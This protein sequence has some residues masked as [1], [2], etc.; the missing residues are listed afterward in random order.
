MLTKNPRRDRSGCVVPS[1]ATARQAP[2]WRA[3]ICIATALA[4]LTACNDAAP[5][6]EPSPYAV[7]RQALTATP[8][9]SFEEPTDWT[10]PTA[11]LLGSSEHTDGSASLD[12]ETTGYTVVTNRTPAGIG[13]LNGNG[14]SVDVRLP[15]LPVSGYQAMQLSLSA[16]SVNLSGVFLGQRELGGMPPGEWSTVQ[17]TVPDYAF[18]AL[19]GGAQDVTIT[20]AFI[21]PSGAGDYLLDRLRFSE[22]DA[23]DPD[24]HEDP[25][26]PARQVAN[27][28]LPSGETMASVGLLA[29]H[30]LRVA[31]RA[32]LVRRDDTGAVAANVGS[33]LTQLGVSA[34]TGTLISAAPVFLAERSRVTSELIHVGNVV[35]Q[36]DTFVPTETVV[37]T[38]EKEAFSLSIRSATTPYSAL[39]VQPD[40]AYGTVQPGRYPSLRLNSRSS[41]R[42]VA[43]AYEFDDFILEPGAVLLLDDADGPIFVR[44]RNTLT[45]RADLFGSGP[46]L[47]AQVLW[48]YEGSATAAIEAPLRGTVVAPNGAVKLATLHGQAPAIVREHRGAV[49]ARDIQLDADVTFRHVPFAFE[50]RHTTTLSSKRVCVNEPIRVSVDALPAAPGADV[51]VAIAGTPTTQRTL[52]FKGAP[53]LRQIPIAISSSGQVETEIVEVEIVDCDE[54]YLSIGVALAL[55]VPGAVEFVVADADGA[56]PSL[57]AGGTYRWTFG[58]GGTQ[59]TPYPALSHGYPVATSTDGLVRSFQVAVELIDASGEVLASGA[60]SV[61]LIN[62]AAMDR[63]AGVLRPRA[64]VVNAPERLPSGDYSARLHIDNVEAEEMSLNEL[65]LEPLPCSE[66]DTPPPSQVTAVAVTVPANTTEIVDVEIDAALVGS[67]VCAVAVSYVGSVGSVTAQASAY[68]ELHATD[69]EVLSDPATAE[70][71]TFALD[72]GLVSEPDTVTD[73]ELLRLARQGRLPIAEAELDF[74]SAPAP[75]AATDDVIGLACVPGDAPPRPGVTCQAVRDAAGN[76]S[77]VRSRAQV[78]NARKGDTLLSAG[79]SPITGLLKRVDP[80]Q[81]FE[82]VGIMSKDRTE[83]RSAFAQIEQIMRYPSSRK[84]ELCHQVRIVWNSKSTTRDVQGLCSALASGSTL[85]D[86]TAS[87]QNLCAQLSTRARVLQAEIDALLASMPSLDADGRQRVQQVVAQLSASQNTCESLKDSSGNPALQYNYCNTIDSC[88]S[89]SQPTDG[90]DERAVK[91][92]WPGSVTQPVNEAF[93]RG[94]LTA[95]DG[96]RMFATVFNAHPQYCGDAS[97]ALVR[98]RVAK[99]PLEFEHATRPRLHAA[100]DNALALDAHYR[101]YAYSEGDI[102]REPSRIPTENS[103][104]PGS[105]GTAPVMCSSFLWRAITDAGFDLG[106]DPNAGDTDPPSGMYLYEKQERRNAANFLYTAIYNMAQGEAPL[107]FLVDAPD[108]IANQFTN[109]FA[110]DLCSPGDWSFLGDTGAD[111]DDWETTGRGITVSPDDILRWAP[112]SEGGPYGAT[113]PLIYRTGGNRVVTQWAVSAGAGRVVGS[114]SLPTGEPVVDAEVSI[115]GYVVTSLADGTFDFGPIDAGDY[116]LDVIGHVDGRV[117]QASVEVTVVAGATATVPVVLADPPP[118]SAWVTFAGSLRILDGETSYDEIRHFLITEGVFVDQTDPTNDITWRSDCVDDEVDVEMNY[119]VE[120]LRDPAV[121]PPVP[122]LP[123]DVTWVPGMV[124]VTVQMGLYEETVCNTSEREDTHT[125]VRYLAP[126]TATEVPFETT[127]DDVSTAPDEASATLTIIN[128]RYWDSTPPERS[129][130]LAGNMH[131]LDYDVIGENETGDQPFDETLTLSELQ[132]AASTTALRKEVDGEVIGRFQAMAVLMPNGRD[133]R[134]YSIEHQ[135][136]GARCQASG[137]WADDVAD[138]EAPELKYRVSDCGN[139]VETTFTVENPA[140]P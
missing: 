57:P 14:V 18:G 46:Q 26:S 59:L 3:P 50:R 62:D 75:A 20:V 124:K 114:V 12:V 11:Q 109:C 95:P 120:F 93:E 91:Y 105:V 42:L 140:D 110:S 78:V 21:V 107:G 17:F 137:A 89:P 127:N 139:Y 100:A 79:C 49:F 7:H 25:P 84:T 134:V 67:G 19:S 122:P 121:T 1:R 69:E 60:R 52:Q 96:T 53:G 123:A 28:E 30:D 27:I 119:T 40:T 8:V 45:I 10:S 81:F 97:Q 68:L 131:I 33:G 76:F 23:P 58:D 94:W 70:A 73:T 129:V 104:W 24:P 112:A 86:A 6:P 22:T 130:R 90:F 74:T 87:A 116:V 125:Q 65:W 103:L 88:D 16:P 9:L 55:D 63:A 111:S 32:V 77:Y 5:P 115:N 61:D 66:T 35:R 133:V 72:H 98:P 113:E 43:G 64:T 82:H 92:G 101:F 106:M 51:H 41:A 29:T 71:L 47:D 99:P 39:D 126:G 31:D 83:V 128:G 15:P 38:L 85:G 2:W 108:D 135:R 136:D 44:V 132:R 13:A 36:N 54:Q 48:V 34:T 138:G 80:P 37:P 117:R 56:T 118:D 102:S 4:V